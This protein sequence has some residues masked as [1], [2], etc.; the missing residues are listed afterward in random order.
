MIDT[1]DS[2]MSLCLILGFP[3]TLPGCK[4]QSSG[5]APPFPIPYVARDVC[6]FECCQYSTWITP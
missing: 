1:M 2:R 4:S 5:Q 6:P 3:L